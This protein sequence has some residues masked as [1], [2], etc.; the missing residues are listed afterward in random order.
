MRTVGEQVERLVGLG[1][2]GGDG[3]TEWVAGHDAC[4]GDA[5][6]VVHPDHV[7]AARG[8]PS[9]RRGTSRASWSGT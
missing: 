1:I 8:P 4:R 7:P 3:L 6:V 9:S 2:P 5:L